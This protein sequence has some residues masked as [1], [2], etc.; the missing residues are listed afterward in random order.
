MINF[1]STDEKFNV[2]IKPCTN[3]DETQDIHIETRKI[4]VTFYDLS[5]VLFV[6][7]FCNH[8]YNIIASQLHC[9]VT[10]ASKY[11]DFVIPVCS[12]MDDTL[13]ALSDHITI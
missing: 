6:D 11:Y 5:Y 7:C 13:S 12:S 4:N 2:T 9:K 1:K 8:Q 10:T 3:A